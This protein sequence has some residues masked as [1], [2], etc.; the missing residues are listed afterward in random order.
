MISTATFIIQW[1]AGRF[2]I[3]HGVS[4]NDQAQQENASRS[5]NLT[6]SHGPDE[7]GHVKCL[8][9]VRGIARGEF[10]APFAR[11]RPEG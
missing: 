7:P 3:K 4:P 8:T 6:H 1:L 5:A 2:L 11:N 10:G 9:Q